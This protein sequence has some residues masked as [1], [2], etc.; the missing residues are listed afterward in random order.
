[1][2]RGPPNLE[3]ACGW[4]EVFRVASSGHVLESSFS[5]NHDRRKAAGAAPTCLSTTLPRLRST[6]VGIAC[7]SNWLLTPGESS[8]FTFTNLSRPANSPA[9]CSS[10]GLTI[11]HGT[12]PGRPDVNKHWD[13]RGL[14]NGGE[15]RVGCVHHPAQ[16]RTALSAARHTLGHGRNAVLRLAVGTHHNLRRG[17]R[18]HAAAL[19]SGGRPFEATTLSSPSTTSTEIIPPFPPHPPQECAD[20]PGLD[21]A[22][23]AQLLPRLGLVTPTASGSLTSGCP[24]EAA[25]LTAVMSRTPGARR[26]GVA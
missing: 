6:N 10:A 20:K 11:R 12:A 17:V 23:N 13:G 25:S 3:T 8:A 18:A 7:T 19:S 9:S 24:T 22:G 21:L 15:V 1:M 26:R 2:Y 14:R 4:S 16:R 5:V